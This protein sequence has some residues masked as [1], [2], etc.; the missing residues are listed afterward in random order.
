VGRYWVDADVLMQAQ[1]SFYSIRIAAPFWNFLERQAGAGKIC[2][3]IKI[4][5][6]IIRR[7]DDELAKWVKQR[8]ACGLFCYPDKEVQD[9][10]RDTVDYVMHAYPQRQA[11][12]TEFLKGGDCWIIAHARCDKGRVVSHENRLDPSAL[13]PKIPNVCHHFGIGCIKLN[14]MLDELNFR[15]EE[16]GR[17][18]DR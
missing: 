5:E 9:C 3:S 10:F 17:G 4:Y 6:E 14:M 2:S 11:K 18:K 12:V 16:P 15:F 8:K 13:Q 1:N 7:E